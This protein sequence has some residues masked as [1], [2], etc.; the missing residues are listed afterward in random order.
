MLAVAV[1][2]VADEGGGDDEGAD[3]ADGADGVVEDAVVGPL[4]EGFFLGLGEAEVDFGAEE[5]GDAGV[6]VV[7]EELLGADE[8]E[9]VFEVAGDV[10]L[11]A[12][13]AGEGE[14]GDAGAEAAGVEGEHAAVFVVGMR[15]DVEDGGAGV[16]L[17]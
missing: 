15:D 10:V 8:A 2:D 5:L 14:V 6:A 17:A 9:R 4:G 12:F 13:A 7:G 3:D 1:G 16:E 11:A